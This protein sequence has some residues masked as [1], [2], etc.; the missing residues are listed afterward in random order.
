MLKQ[1]ERK[2]KEKDASSVLR[3]SLCPFPQLNKHI[4]ETLC[5]IH[6]HP[7]VSHKIQI[8]K[9]V[10]KKLK[11]KIIKNNKKNHPAQSD[12][13]FQLRLRF[14][15]N[16]FLFSLPLLIQTQNKIKEK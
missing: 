8:S 15:A 5:P 14:H 12:R 11:R 13:D 4:N 6:L 7:A 9:F 10:S 2:R 1:T 16:H 3:G